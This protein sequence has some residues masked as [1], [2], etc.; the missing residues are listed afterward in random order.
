MEGMFGTI[1]DSTHVEV[2]DR[3]ETTEE[4]QLKNFVALASQ[5]EALEL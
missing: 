1:S 5:K 2:V 4:A 3:S